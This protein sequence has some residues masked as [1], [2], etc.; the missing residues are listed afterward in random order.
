LLFDMGFVQP[1]GDG[2]RLSL[3]MDEDGEAL[4][5]VRPVK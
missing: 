1:E 4:D 3:A 2:A 5:S